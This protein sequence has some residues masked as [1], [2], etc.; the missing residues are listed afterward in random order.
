MKA[1]L[2]ALALVLSAT[3]VDA[4]PV[5]IDRLAPA[6]SVQH[7]HLAEFASNVTLW[8]TVA[9]DTWDAAHAAEPKRALF[10]EGIRD[11]SVMAL[12]V[13]VKVLVHRT[14]PCAPDCGVD[15]PHY[16]FWSGHTALAFASS[17]RRVQITIPL[18]ASTGYFRIAAD[19][20]WLTD[21][22]AGAG[23]GALV[24]RLRP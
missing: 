9:I 20:H 11:G 2:F 21:T 3:T 1:L 17:G 14:R 13:V 23:I 16:S 10:T 15:D 6:W 7:R 22:L 5:P 12:G 18:A 19:K 24:S 4:Q 8:S